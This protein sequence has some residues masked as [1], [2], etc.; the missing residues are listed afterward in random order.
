MKLVV[1][2][3]TDTK[4]L[5]DFLSELNRNGV[6]GATIINSTGMARTL[7]KNDD[8]QFIGSLKMIFD[9][10]RKESHVILIA[11][12]DEKVQTVFTCIKKICGDLCGPDTGI[13]FTV[14]IDDVV[15]F[16]S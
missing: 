11:L 16:K 3:M 15:G 2:V 13:A 9:K 8:M 4:Y 14:P 12:P 10:S 7:A 6:K 5:E 1:Y